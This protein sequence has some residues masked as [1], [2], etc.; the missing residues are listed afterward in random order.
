[1]HNCE[2]IIN[3][4]GASG[5]C[6]DRGLGDALRECEDGNLVDA[7]GWYGGT[8]LAVQPKCEEGNLAHTSGWYGGT[9]LAVQA[10][11]SPFPSRGQAGLSMR[12]GDVDLSIPERRQSHRIVPVMLAGKRTPSNMQ[13][14][15]GGEIRRSKSEIRRAG[16]S[17]KSFGR[18]RVGTT[19]GGKQGGGRRTEE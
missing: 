16:R 13:N 6:G 4:D 18:T 8:D 7:S 17:S 2:K 19:E 1:M 10:N 3:G 15:H 5:W 12:R 11:S 9:R 14:E